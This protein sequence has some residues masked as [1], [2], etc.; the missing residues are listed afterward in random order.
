MNNASLP[1]PHTGNGGI[2]IS[3]SV[4]D[5]LPPQFVKWY[6]ETFRGT[7]MIFGHWSLG[8]LTRADGVA[9]RQIAVLRPA[10][11]EEMLARY[12]DARNRRVGGMLGGLWRQ[13]EELKRKAEIQVFDNAP[14]NADLEGHTLGRDR[15]SIAISVMGGKGARPNDLGFMAPLPVQLQEMIR[16]VADA[17]IATRTPVE[18]FMT[19]SEAADNL[20]LPRMDAPAAPHP[21]RGFRTVREIWD[22]EAWVDTENGSLEAPLHSARVGWTRL[23]DWIREHAL[24]TLASRTHDE[25]TH[26]AP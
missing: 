10:E 15:N 16:Q 7:R 25:W 19:A 23:G 11:L 2:T 8:S 17:C 5:T 4:Y 9:H 24:R 14:W 3:S 12:E 22:L 18:R 13:I 20:D 6:A 26:E 1:L 21:P